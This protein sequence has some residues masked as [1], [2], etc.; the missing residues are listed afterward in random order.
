[1][2]SWLRAD[3]SGVSDVTRAIAGLTERASQHND[4]VE[5]P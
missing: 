3:D 2:G 5:T 1:M 4:L